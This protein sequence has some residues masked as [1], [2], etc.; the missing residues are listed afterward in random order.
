MASERSAGRRRPERFAIGARSVDDWTATRS[1]AMKRTLIRYKARP[2]RAEE[3]EALIKNVFKELQEKSPEDVRYLVIKLAD[4]TFVHFVGVETKDG[5]NPIPA[6][7][8]FR[9]FQNGIKDRCMEPAQSGDATIVG[10]YR[11]L[12]ER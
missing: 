5:S 1:M 12:A 6:L 7:D 4:G 10:N 8:A 11:M 2:E 3:N 9:S